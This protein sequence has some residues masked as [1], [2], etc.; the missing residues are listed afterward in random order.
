VDYSVKNRQKSKLFCILVDC[1]YTFIREAQPE[2]LGEGQI[3]SQRNL[4]MKHRIITSIIVA[5][6]CIS[7]QN[8]AFAVLIVEDHF[9]TS[10][11][12]YTADATITTTSPNDTVGYNGTDAWTTTAL[13]DSVDFRAR[14]A[15]LSYTDSNGAALVV[16]GGHLE[17]YRV[18]QGNFTK[19]VHRIT[20]DATTTDKVGDEVWFSLL[21]NTDDANFIS[22]QRAYFGWDQQHGSGRE[23]GIE[24]DGSKF[25]NNLLI[26]A[27]QNG[28]RNTGLTL[29]DGTNLLV[30]RLTDTDTYVDG[31]GN[32]SNDSF[33]LFLNPT[34]ATAPTGVADYRLQG[35]FMLVG[36]SHSSF[37]F[38]RTRTFFNLS[39]NSVLFDEFR[40]GDTFADVTP[41]AA[42]P[43]P[44]TATLAMLGLGGL[45]V[46]R[47]RTA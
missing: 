16:A 35:G 29:E 25:G 9:L 4:N 46:R 39:D 44:A 11:G 17:N 7:F 28:T 8:V 42:V 32:A 43:E 6:L 31:T 37:G 13:N 3:I 41:A 45:M 27:G 34:L 1:H 24:F 47:R 36:G 10:P 21:V 19:I 12:N 23:F 20:T 33:E 26:R 38:D 2:L 40:L 30:V 18:G 14:A 15:G 22:G 5:L